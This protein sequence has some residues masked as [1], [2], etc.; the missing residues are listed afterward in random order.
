MFALSATAASAAENMLVGFQD[1]E[2]FRIRPDRAQMLDRAMQADGQIIRATVNWSLIA[3][4]KPKNAKDPFDP[5]YNFRDVDELA[6]GAQ[7]RGMEMLLTIWGV[8]K[9]ANGNQKPN[10][11]PRHVGD[12]SQFAFALASRY[13]GRYPGYPFVRYYSIWNEPNLEQFLAPQ[14]DKKGRDVAPRLYA[15]LVRATYA[16]IKA[17]NSLA[18]VAIGETSARG[19]DHLKKGGL[20]QPTHSPGRFAE[21]V[22]KQRPRVPFDAW[23]HHPYPTTPSMKPMQIVKWP[24]VTLPSLPRFEASLDKW[25]GRKNIP[26]WITEYGHET[27]PDEKKGVTYAQQAAYARQALEFVKADARVPMFIWFVLRD[28]PANPWQSGLI[29]RNGTLKP[30]F[31]VV[32]QEATDVDPRT[33]SIAIKADA[34]APVVRISTIEFA[35]FSQPGAPIGVDYHVWEQPWEV[36]KQSPEVPLAIDGWVSLPLQFM[37]EAGHTYDLYITAYDPHGNRIDRKLQLVAS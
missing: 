3:K 33:G 35:R 23:A 4:R 24:N 36:V 9:W 32:T 8:P 14:F 20:T 28:D 16:P 11:M 10:R 12:L 6:R 34:F 17:A 21:L 19:R 18:Q 7:I 27:K 15:Q 5:A 1:D 2:S 29:R 31:A 30:A 13:S 22:S 37:P 25:F 26:V